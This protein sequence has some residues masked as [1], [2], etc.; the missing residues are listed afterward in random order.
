MVK[1]GSEPKAGG[2]DEMELKGLSEVE[3][4]DFGSRLH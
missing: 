4:V 3:V 2:D 1:C